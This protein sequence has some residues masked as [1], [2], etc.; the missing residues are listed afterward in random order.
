M[1]QLLWCMGEEEREE[2]AFLGHPFRY[3][4]EEI[5]LEKEK[6]HLESCAQSAHEWK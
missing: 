3:F 4:G 5:H 1:F 6:K 2:G